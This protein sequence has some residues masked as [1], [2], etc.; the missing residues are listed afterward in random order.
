MSAQTILRYSWFDMVTPSEPELLTMLRLLYG[1]NWFRIPR[2]KWEDLWRLRR[3]YLNSLLGMR[4][5]NGP[6]FQRGIIIA[7]AA[8]QHSQ[9]GT[10]PVLT[11]ITHSLTHVAPT[12]SRQQYAYDS[13]G[14]MEHDLNAEAESTIVYTDLTT[15]TNDTNNHTNEWWPDQPDVNEGL[16]WDIRYLNFVDAGPRP[17]T[18]AHLLADSTGTNRVSGTWYLLDTISNDHADASHDGGIGC[19]HNNGTAKNPSGGTSTMT[20][21]VEI[22]VTGSGSAVAS[23]SYDLDVNGS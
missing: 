4:R 10:V 22:R 2:R 23:H 11:D 6:K 16:N 3:G 8:Y 19:N 20:V 5:L 17:L 13:D 14:S 18:A 15:Q 7:T 1:P 21:D 9:G 12:P